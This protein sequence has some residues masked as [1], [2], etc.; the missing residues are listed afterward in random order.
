MLRKQI[1]KKLFR[2]INVNDIYLLHAGQNIL[3]FW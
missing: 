3:Q 2:I 1:A